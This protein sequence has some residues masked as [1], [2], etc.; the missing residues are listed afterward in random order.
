MTVSESTDSRFHITLFV[1]ESIGSNSIIAFSILGRKKAENPL[2]QFISRS[3]VHYHWFLR[4][5]TLQGVE[6]VFGELT[7]SWILILTS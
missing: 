7:G 1:T 2:A 5:R 3:Y 4:S 6:D